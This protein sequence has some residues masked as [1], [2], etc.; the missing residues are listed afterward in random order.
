VQQSAEKVL[1]DDRFNLDKENVFI[2]GGSHGGFLTCHLIGQYPHFYKAV[3]S[4]LVYYYLT[5]FSVV[6]FFNL[7]RQLVTL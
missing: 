3:R 5:F 6:T 4:R 1:A 7:R 2:T